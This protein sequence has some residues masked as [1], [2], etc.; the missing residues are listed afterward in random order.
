MRPFPALILVSALAGIAGCDRK[1]ATTT[2][3][4]GP[5]V[6]T[7]TPPA[8]APAASAGI[9]G[10]Y[11]MVG[12][13]LWGDAIRPE[14]IAKEPEAEKLI[15]ITQDTIEMRMFGKPEK[16]KYTIDPSK[17]PKEIDT[18]IPEKGMKDTTSYGIYKVEGDTLTLFLIGAKD[19]KNRPKEFKTV[20]PLTE[21]GEG[22]DGGLFFV[23][24][25]KK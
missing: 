25:K 5:G 9:E 13:E 14:G 6:T 12:G 7:A 11:L 16:L 18:V 15:R 23:I 10:E 19:P 17:S 24:A 22:N 4:A 2:G 21:K 3:P 8:P 1:D 20:K